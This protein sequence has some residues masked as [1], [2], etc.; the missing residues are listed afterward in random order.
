MR[1][2]QAVHLP[3]AEAHREVAFTLFHRLERIVP[4]GIVHIHGT[5]FD[6]MF[7]RVADDLRRRIESHGLA[8]QERGAENVRV[9]TLD[10]GGNIDEQ[11][12]GGRVAF[13]KAVF[14]EAL[15]LVEAGLCKGG[16]IPTCDHPANQ[17]VFVIADR[18][19]IAERGHRAAQAVDFL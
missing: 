3:E 4:V 12:K 2:R 1:L 9:M 17:H 19:N 10:P 6:A 15:D 5:H 7:L 16:V 13:R 8:V 18:A 11:S 14:A